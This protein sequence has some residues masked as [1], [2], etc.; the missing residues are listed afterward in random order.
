MRSDEGNRERPRR[1]T[2]RSIIRFFRQCLE[3]GIALEIDGLGVLRRNPDGELVLAP[4][5]QPKVFLAYVEEN[6]PEAMKIYAALKARG[7]D[8]W[9]DKEKLLPG[10]N[11]PR[12]IES[13]IEV[14]D[15][16]VPL[17]SR[18]SIRKRGQFQTEL[19]YALECASRMP[20]DSNFLVP[21][22]LEE[23]RV[24]A[25]ISNSIQ[26]VDLFP[27]WDKG[28]GRLLETVSQGT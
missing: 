11:W 6:L 10:Q 3:D 8:P 7:C 27:D 21:L 16:F 26:Y 13:A 15:Y 28:L 12:R 17:F 23:C 19:R 24:P 20:M 25:R 14:A 22:R 1:V 4:F 2:A 5:T 9:L 18:H